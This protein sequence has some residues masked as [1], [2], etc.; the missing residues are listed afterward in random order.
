MVPTQAHLGD[1]QEELEAFEAQR[2]L[3]SSTDASA[4]NSP[5]L[6]VHHSLAK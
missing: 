4:F 2:L 6:L 1:L 5:L 3:D